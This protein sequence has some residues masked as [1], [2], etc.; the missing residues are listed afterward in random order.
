M[1]V[2][3]A[4]D[5]AWIWGVCGNVTNKKLPK[6]KSTLGVHQGDAFDQ[7]IKSTIKPAG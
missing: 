4:V 1:L 2:G 7:T 5:L 6:N 3:V